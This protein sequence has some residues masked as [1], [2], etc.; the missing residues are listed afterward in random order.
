MKKIIL[1]VLLVLS[2]SVINAKETKV[3]PILDADYCPAPTIALIGGVTKF[4]GASSAGKTYG[5]EL[6]FAC[7]IFQIDGLEINQILS[8]THYS[9]NG[10]SINALEMN[11]RLVFELSPD[12]KIGFGPGL[13]LLRVNG[14]TEFGLNAGVSLNYALYGNTF[15]GIETRKQWVNSDSALDNQKTLLKIGT[16]F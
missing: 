11:P 16:H 15:V 1:S 6:G 13:G 2:T 12:L 14:A 4:S 3:L 9:H 8:A 5:L 10:S 7:P